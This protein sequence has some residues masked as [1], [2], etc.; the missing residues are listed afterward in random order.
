VEVQ[1]DRT[2]V[3]FRAGARYVELI[4]I[5]G[6]WR[7]EVRIDYRTGYRF[8]YV[9]TIVIVAQDWKAYLSLETNK[10]EASA[11]IRA[12]RGE[13]KN[14]KL[15]ARKAKEILDATK[16]LVGSTLGLMLRA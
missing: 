8:H 9:V 2:I 5:D 11:L 6:K 10:E 7:M 12:M 15:A 14:E 3:T 4:S 16:A 13:P 1:V